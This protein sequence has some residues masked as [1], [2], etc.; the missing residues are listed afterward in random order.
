MEPA[1]EK[2]VVGFQCRL[3]DPRLQGFPGD[4][5]D[6]ELHRTFGL[7]LHDVG[8]GGYLLSVG[9]VTDLE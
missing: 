9:D 4:G 8:S 3:L 2:E 6:L 5:C 7:V 1:R